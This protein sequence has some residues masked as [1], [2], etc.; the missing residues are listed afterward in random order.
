MFHRREAGEFT[1]AG[2]WRRGG[3]WF[4]GSP[5]VS[6][7][8]AMKLI[9]VG[10]SN[11]VMNP[12]WLPSFIRKLERQHGLRLSVVSNHA[13]GNTTTGYGLYRLA[14]DPMLVEADV[15]MIEYAIN[16][17][18]AYTNNVGRTHW[19][20]LYEGV[21]RYALSVNPRLK[22]IS[23]IFETK[24]VAT[25]SGIPPISA[26]I[27][28]I[29]EWYGV[30]Q[31]NI[32]RE[33]IRRYGAEMLFEPDFYVEND[34]A[35][36]GRS[37]GVPLVAEIIAEIFMLW[38]AVDQSNAVLPRPIDTGEYSGAKAFDI[39]RFAKL[40]GFDATQFGNS[41]FQVE[42]FNLAQRSFRLRLKHGRLLG[43][44]YVC[45]RNTAPFYISLENR[46]WECDPMK[47]GVKNG[48]YS[49]L[50]S[51]MPCEFLFG[52]G[53]LAPEKSDDALIVISASPPGAVTH[54]WIPRDGSPYDPQPGGAAPG[55]PVKGILYSGEMLGCSIRADGHEAL[56]AAG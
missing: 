34:S 5:T 49:F 55:F 9:V 21:I 2:T 43:I 33:I 24:T 22:I 30:G 45:A 52:D 39:A 25:S 53:L 40:E 54:K 35:H 51:N 11:T 31:I 48:T 10:G 28:Y 14:S 32:T 46:I 27:G 1:G 15:L 16:D 36:Y 12:G 50:L 18:F 17:E 56:A 6:E 13:T 29:S 7:R 38:A 3:G 37:V 20:R 42:T 19:A 8:D 26:N 41:R 4:Q 47:D 23:V 44:E